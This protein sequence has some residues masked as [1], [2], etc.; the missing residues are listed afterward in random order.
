ML[1]QKIS[2]S[3]KK[4][5]AEHPKL[6]SVF[7]L[8]CANVFNNL[9]TFIAN[10]I[11]ARKFGPEY[12]GVFSLATSVMMVAYM[13]ADMG[14]NL[15]MV[16][17]FNLYTGNKKQQNQLL[18]SLLLLRFS[19]VLAFF[20][21]SPLLGIQL[22]IAFKL[23]NSYIILFALAISS[24]GL[25]SLWMYLQNFLQAHKQFSKLAVYI[26]V[27]GI[28]RIAC[29]LYIYLTLN[30]QI[31]P[32][33]A[34]ESLYSI[35]VFIVIIIGLLPIVRYLFTN[36]LPSISIVKGFLRQ[37]LKYSKW[38]A[39]SGICY[40]FIYRVVQFLLALLS[41]QQELGILSAGFIFTVAFATLNVAVKTVFFPY[42]T[43]LQKIDDIGRHLSRLKRILPYY[44][45]IVI[46]GIAFLSIIQMV[47]LDMRYTY[48][49]PVFW[50]SSIALASTVFMGLI[51]MLLHTL[52]RPEIDAFVN[53]VRL[54]V[55]GILTYFLVPLWGAIGG[56]VAYS[57]VLLLG[58]V[59]LVLKV[60]CLLQEK[61]RN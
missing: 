60:R 21:L 58:E 43:G 13:I 36:G 59:Y 29:F 27:Y 22:S 25:L 12:F 32:F 3:V 17:Y 14:F 52:M 16:R 57:S 50:I 30:K 19:L 7:I 23:N 4:I 40:G 55:V 41:T 15:T 56:A 42:V 47:F 53:I 20:A 61:I 24:G 46:V 28:L 2:D 11:L 31:T 5:V 44:I 1:I 37:A 38:V 8:L 18:S 51:S 49:L 34:I 33:V 26:V 10:L 9:F 6:F 54:I 48:A 39:I 35:P 45:I